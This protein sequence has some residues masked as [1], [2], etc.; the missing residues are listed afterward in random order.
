MSKHRVFGASIVLLLASLSPALALDNVVIGDGRC[1]CMCETANTSNYNEYDSAGYGC[2][3]LENKTCNSENPATGLI[4]TG[5]LWGCSPTNDNMQST[6]P[7]NG[8]FDPT[9]GGGPVIVRPGVVGP[10]QM[11]RQ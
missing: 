8:V 9:T 5:R 2:G 1:D 10:L 7:L 3:A 6:A 11:F 4:E